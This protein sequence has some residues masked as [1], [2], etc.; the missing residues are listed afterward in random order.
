MARR[1]PSASAPA[2]S[3]VGLPVLPDGSRRRPL[4]IGLGSDARCNNGCDPCLSRAIPDRSAE[5]RGAHVVI[6]DREPTL[7]DDLL[8]HVRALRDASTVSLLTNGRMLVYEE[9]ASAL[10]NAGLDRVI[11]KLF[12][13]DAASHDAHTRAQGSF[14]Q[15]LDGIASARRAGLET[16]VTFPLPV[17]DQE[18]REALARELTSAEPVVFPEPEVE[19]HANEYRYDVVELRGRARGPLWRK[20]FFPMVHVQTGP[21]CNIRCTYCNVHGGDD[22]RLYEGV[23]VRRLIDAAAEQVL[24]PHA[25]NGVPTVDFIGGEPTLHPELPGFIA[26]ARARGFAQVLVC[27]NGLRL[28]Q[29]GYLDELLEAGLTGV[30]L[31][32]HDHRANQAAA[33]ADV[34]AAIGPRYP[35]IAELLL[36]RPEL[37]T[38]F[39]RILLASTLDAVPDYLRWLAERNRLGRP[40]DLTF[41]MPSMRGRLFDHPELY[42]KLEGLRAK[43]EA[44]VALAVDLGIE[45]VVH[46]APAC[47][48]PTSPERAAC[49][50]I[51]T[52]QRSGLDGTSE[53]TNF[54][55]DARYGA[56]CER[57]EGKRLGCHG[58]PAAYWDRDAAESEA[59]LTPI[60]YDPT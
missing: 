16:H 40:I 17:G 46:H 4:L 33:L 58:L 2:R 35:E 56:A 6:R 44:A 59:W 30:R 36:G 13:L 15:A 34:G 23:D 41:G 45:P 28:A 9:R 60:S 38:H 14:A 10:Q 11:V 51:S 24:L 18:A 21:A 37:R 50:H 54:E 7:R 32:F 26:H 5:T 43:V 12:G 48:T 31:S 57:C 20:S 42:P 49:L 19:A 47:L 27:T 53:E 1:E 29:P 3:R 22:Q 55:G 39:Y 25:G 52:Q 8:A